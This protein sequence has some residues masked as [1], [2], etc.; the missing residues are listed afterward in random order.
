VAVVLLADYLV[1]VAATTQVR[2]S[3]VIMGE[4]VEQGRSAW[5]L[6]V[7]V[8]QDRSFAAASATIL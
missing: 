4:P 3:A 2:R 1:V 6:I 8:L 5:G 7:A